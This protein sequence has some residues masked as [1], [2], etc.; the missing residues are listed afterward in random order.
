VPRSDEELASAI[1]GCSTLIWIPRD[2]LDNLAFRTRKIGIG[3]QY[4]AA[5]RNYR[6]GRVKIST[7]NHTHKSGLPTSCVKIAKWL[8]IYGFGQDVVPPLGEIGVGCVNHQMLFKR[9]TYGKQRI[10]SPKV[11]ELIFKTIPY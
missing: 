7:F 11:I 9:Y 5:T 10:F 6:P 1:L 8:N 2:I 4:V 3:S